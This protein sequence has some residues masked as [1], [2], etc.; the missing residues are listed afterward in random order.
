VT[1]HR[2]KRLPVALKADFTEATLLVSLF[3][4]WIKLFQ[5]SDLNHIKFIIFN[6]TRWKGFYH[7]IVRG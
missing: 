2:N 5:N 1:V 7:K 4:Y 6:F 3:C